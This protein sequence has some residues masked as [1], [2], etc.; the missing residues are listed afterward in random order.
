M[1]AERLPV[2]LE[3]NAIIARLSFGVGFIPIDSVWESAL[4]DCQECLEPSA[5]TARLPFGLDYYLSVIYRWGL[6]MDGLELAAM[7]AD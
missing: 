1:V 5:I 4:R 6:E 2:G 3:P 7:V